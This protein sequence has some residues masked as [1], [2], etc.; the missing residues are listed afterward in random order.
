[1][2]CFKRAVDII[3]SKLI[4]SRNKLID[5]EFEKLLNRLIDLCK[6]DDNWEEHYK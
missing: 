2:K 6:N 1:V 3:K 5:E 4:D